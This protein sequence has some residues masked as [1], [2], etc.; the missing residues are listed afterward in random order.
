MACPF[1]LRFPKLGRGEGRVE[2]ASVKVDD[3]RMMEQRMHGGRGPRPPHSQHTHAWG[4]E[5]KPDVVRARS[6]LDGNLN[7]DLF[8]R[9]ISR[10]RRQ[11]TTH[12]ATISCSFSTSWSMKLGSILGAGG[13]STE[14]QS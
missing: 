12:P 5:Y 3:G 1:S 13:D 11:A 2:S 14:G 10:A 4:A 8:A 7:D 9:Q 6:A